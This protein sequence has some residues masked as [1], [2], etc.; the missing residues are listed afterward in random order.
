MTHIHYHFYVCSGLASEKLFG[1]FL[2]LVV[3]VVLLLFPSHIQQC[4]PGLALGYPPRLCGG[5]IWNARDQSWHPKC[6]VVPYLLWYFSAQIFSN[7]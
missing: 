5:E 7:Y 3:V 6:Q 1:C 2:L 4:Y